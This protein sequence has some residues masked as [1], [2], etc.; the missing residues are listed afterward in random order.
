MIK[1]IAKEQAF[2]KNLL[3]VPQV[4]LLTCSSIFFKQIINSMLKKIICLRTN[5][6]ITNICDN[7]QQL[8]QNMYLNLQWL[9]LNEQNYLKKAVVQTIINDYNITSLAKNKPKILVIEQIEYCTLEAGNSFLQFLENVPEN[10]YLLLV[11]SNLA[12][13]MTTIKSRSQIMI[14]SR[15]EN[16]QL[17]TLM[18]TE[19]RNDELLLLTIIS[20]TFNFDI[21][22]FTSFEVNQ[23]LKL[24]LEFINN[25]NKS[26]YSANFFLIKKLLVLK[27]KSILFFYLLLFL[28]YKKLLLPHFANYY[29]LKVDS[30]LINKLLK[31]WKTQ[32]EVFLLKILQAINQ[33]NQR[34]SKKINLTLLF[35]YFFITI[36]EGYNDIDE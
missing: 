2:F 16:L 7:C 1:P 36:Y 11:T 14:L 13:V 5:C 9:V 35:N 21:N 12:Q 26:N 32:D 28:I 23:T 19:N 10:T 4:M 29:Q 24:V 34:F 31:K 15:A 22:K 6:Q 33:I 17:Q 8:S 27:E 30:L 20:L 3:H 18:L 25:D